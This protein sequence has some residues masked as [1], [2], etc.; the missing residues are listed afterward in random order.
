MIFRNEDL[1]FSRSR[2]EFAE[3]AIEDLLW[4]GIDW[5]EG[6]GRAGANAPYNQSERL[7]L[8]RSAFADLVAR[9]LVYPCTCSRQDVLQAL[10]APHE[11][12]DEPVYPGTCSRRS[13]SDALTIDKSKR[14]SW[15]FRVADGHQVAFNDGKYGAQ[16]FVAGQDFGDFV[17]WRHDDL[18]SYQLACVCDD[19]AMQITEIVRGQ[20]LLISTARQILLYQA[21]ATAVPQFYHC[22]L[23]LDE[24][25]VRLAKR[26]DALT[27]RTLRREGHAADQLKE[28]FTASGGTRFQLKSVRS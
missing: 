17:V 3:A 12:A 14:V 15:R 21:F 11:G 7:E 16:S 6:P 28:Q 25:G 5:H 20:D 22:P 8:Y 2:T 26:H 19:T 24:N 13:A 10:S 4:L 23:I 18:P 9:N 1:D 27:V